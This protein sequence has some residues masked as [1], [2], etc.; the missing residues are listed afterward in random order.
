VWGLRR[1]DWALM[2]TVKQKL[3]PH[4]LFNPGRFVGGI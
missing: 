2:R 4:G 3:D 1:G